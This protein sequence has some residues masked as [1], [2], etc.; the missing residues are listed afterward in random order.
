[1][2]FPQQT[3]TAE[4]RKWRLHKIDPAEMNQVRSGIVVGTIFNDAYDL[5][6]DGDLAVI[7]FVD[8]VESPNFFLAVTH[9]SCV[10]CMKDEEKK[11]DGGDT[12]S[13]SG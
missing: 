3:I 1:M 8:W 9:H 5:Y 4:L 6:E 7:H 11:D 10:K 12:P 13:P 2:T